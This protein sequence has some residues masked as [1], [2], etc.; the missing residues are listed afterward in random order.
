MWIYV[1]HR[2]EHATEQPF[3]C[4][5]YVTILWQL[6]DN[7]VTI[8]LQSRYF[9]VTIMLQLCYNFVTAV[10]HLHYICVTILLLEHRKRPNPPRFYHRFPSNVN[11]QIAQ[12]FSKFFYPRI[13]KLFTIHKK[14]TFTPQKLFFVQPAQNFSDRILIFCTPCTKIF[15]ILG[16]ANL[17]GS[18]I[19]KSGRG[20]IP[21]D[22]LNT[23]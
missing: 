23:R 9:Y 10:L 15:W 18:A 22:T 21:Q 2:R 16:L 5:N 8:M 14:F 20:G 17:A 1:F 19:L 12:I 11:R 6:Y 3:L 4:Y 7:Y 13:Y